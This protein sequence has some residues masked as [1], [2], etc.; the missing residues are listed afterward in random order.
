MKK[1]LLALTILPF[2]LTSCSLFNDIFDSGES[3]TYTSRN[4]SESSSGDITSNNTSSK[5]STSSSTYVAPHIVFDSEGF[6]YEE[7]TEN[8]LITMKRGSSITLNAVIAN[9]DSS[10][11]SLIYSWLRG[12]DYGT[13]NNNTVR[14]NDDAPINARPYVKIELKKN[15]H[16]DAIDIVLIRI[17]V[18]DKYT[19]SLIS[20]SDDVVVTTSSQTLVDFDISVPLANKFYELPV[21]KLE[22]YDGQ[23]NVEFVNDDS[24]YYKDKIE[25][26]NEENTTY[27]QIVDKYNMLS[28]Y[29]FH[30]M[31]RDTDNKLLRDVIIAATETLNSEDVLTVYYG[32]YFDKISKGQTMTIEKEETAPIALTSYFNGNVL[33]TYSTSYSV[34]S[35]DDT[36]AYI[37]KKYIGGTSKYVINP[38]GKVGTTK[39]SV[40]YYFS[41]RETTYTIDFYIQVVDNKTLESVYVPAGEKAFSISGNN[42]YVNGKIYA[43]Y[44]VGEPEAI[45]GH[46]NLNISVANGNANGT[47]NVTVEFTYRGVTKGHVYVVH[48]QPE[49]SYQKT[50]LSRNYQSVWRQ[51]GFTTMPY[52]GDA[53][54]LVI[55]I[56]F[57][58]SP[59]YI[60]VDKKDE[61]GLNQKQQIIED[62]NTVLFGEN[63]QVPWRSL[64]TYYRE[65]SYGA[66]NIDGKVSD[67]YEV[68]KASTS[69]AYQDTKIS[70]LAVSAVNWYFANNPSE[71]RSDFD[72]NGDGKIDTLIL[73]YG[74]NYHCFRDN[75]Q[76]QTSNWLRRVNVS[77]DTSISNYSWMS[78]ATIYNIDG[79]KTTMTNQLEASDLSLLFGLESKTAIHEIGHAIGLSDYYDKTMTSEPVGVLNMQSS[80]SGGHDAYSVMAYGWA[81]P[82]VFSR[83]DTSLSNEIEI[84][85]NDFQAS[86]DMILLTPQW[87]SSNEA[88]DEYMLLEL[89]TPTGLNRKDALRDDVNN[90]NVPGIRLWHVNAKLGSNYR[91][92]HDNTS[93]STNYDLLHLI[94]NDVNKDYR[95]LSRMSN[96]DLFKQGESFNM[97]TFK[98]QFYNH[99]G[100]LDDGRSLGWRFEVKTINE[101]SYGNATATIKLIKE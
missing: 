42:V 13:I 6:E 85:I 40:S 96:E 64:K 31:I 79:L 98:S 80:D 94:R 100:K 60:N 48:S 77:G 83:N 89:Y 10:E 68:D 57:T 26:R 27:F 54:A 5:P 36:V 23:Y 39:V 81:K 61:N 33:A 87:S 69:Y 56:W 20:K 63:D 86:G 22:G 67:W 88:F 7:E 50:N 29:R 16:Q 32:D 37:S 45:N 25:F 59:D 51:A 97:N 70:D 14:I 30:A 43:I 11:Y 12:G 55:P 90:A 21:V 71:T 4:S 35:E 19:V 84:T 74:T 91:H 52:K 17:T 92:L 95:S 62:M 58:D 24:D 15:G 75:G 34:T 44:S 41:N 9:G 28:N 46:P 1:K 66:L 73:Y 38:V 2:L 47:K 99:D 76:P 82:Y 8:Y 18:I 65:E 49:G 93:N 101:D 53:R 3:Y 78:Y 72:K